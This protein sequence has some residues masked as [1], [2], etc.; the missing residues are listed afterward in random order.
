[1]AAEM[2]FEYIRP[3]CPGVLAHQRTGMRLQAIPDDKQW[4][5][6]VG[7]ERLEKF[8][9]LFLLDAVLVQPEQAVR[10]R[11]GCATFAQP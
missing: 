1:M 11:Q 9:N 5:L 2:R 4:L 7:L 3:G 10:A 6:Q 8:D